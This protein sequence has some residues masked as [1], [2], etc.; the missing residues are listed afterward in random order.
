MPNA[1]ASAPAAAASAPS[2]EPAARVEIQAAPADG[3]A[4]RRG[5]T[6]P[7]IVITREDIDRFGDSSVGELLRRLPG[8]AAS[9]P[10]G[11]SGAP[12]MRGLGGGYT[13]IL[14]DGQRVPSGFS[15]ES[16]SPDQIERI[17]VLRAPTVETG[18]RAVAGTIHIITRNGF[19]QH[20]TEWRLA[21]ARE[22]A[23]LQPSLGWQ[24]AGGA[25]AMGYNVNASVF[26]S[27]S[28][29]QSAVTTRTDR[30]PAQTGGD[31]L[32]DERSTSVDRRTG[33]RAGGRWQWRLG[34]G[35]SLTLAPFL[36][37][38]QGTSSREAAQQALI[39]AEPPWA[40]ART[41]GESRFTLARLNAV[42][43]GLAADG[44]R[45][46]ATALGSLVRSA[47]Q[48]VRRE[49]DAQGVPGRVLTDDA[50][51]R[52]HT[53]TATAKAS[54]LIDDQHSLVAGIEAEHTSRR[55][56]ADST[57][58]VVDA[59]DIGNLAARVQRAAAFV[60]DDWTLSP[61]W[62]AQLGLR[63]EGIAVAAE[64]ADGVPLRN[65]A[66]VWTPVAH[67]L[68]KPDPARRDQWR[69][70]VTRSWRAPS[71]QSLVARPVVNPCC[72]ADG[73]NDPAHP[74]RVGN[75]ALRPELATGI[76]L[77]IERWL[78]G[79]GLLSANLFHRRV[80]DLIRSTTAQV[81]DPAWA[82]GPRWV[83]QPRNVGAAVTQGLELEAR[84]RVAQRTDLRANLSLYRSRVDGVPGPDNRLEQQPGA[85]LNLGID[86][87][88]ASLP[89]TLG[90][91]FGVTAGGA[92]QLS[93]SQRT[94][95]GSRR[96]L[97]AYATWAVRPGLTLRLS[98]ANLV[99]RDARSATEFTAEDIALRTDTVTQAGSSIQIRAEWKL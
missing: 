47:G 63:W 1:P 79:G 89:L 21:V 99:P 36:I 64:Q 50:R 97:D 75:P 15:L 87:R 27:A 65:R 17:E 23:H 67:L 38:S 44:T 11:R 57:G 68:W 22:G 19:R 86:R 72:S 13:Q 39:G 51:S 12:R 70:S 41:A 9:G 60:Q 95:V 24:H 58:A 42:W 78:P 25:A 82:T 84:G 83:A 8:V 71:L 74:D 45:L 18:N 46:E 62:Q 10:P 98:A 55:E 5:A 35:E 81:D 53:A 4:Q 3:D 66:S 20:L 2:A 90:A 93:D 32:R 94:W 7:A 16:L 69:L 59:G 88:L 52:E 56:S 48:T 96:T 37:H 54:R 40:E 61:R 91:G 43:R 29:G 85:L 49:A 34:E 33:M 73:P 80:R 28:P 77:A 6:A 31:E 14:I 26:D 92:T 76:D 30:S